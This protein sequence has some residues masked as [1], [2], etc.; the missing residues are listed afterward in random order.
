METRAHHILIGLFTALA[1]AGL[2]LFVMWKSQSVADSEMKHYDILFREAVSGLSVGS[3][4]QYSGIRVGDVERLTLD[5]QD[6][7][8]VW[9]RVRVAGDTPV[10]VDTSARLALLNIT[11]AS[12]IELSQGTPQ[13][14]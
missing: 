2:M 4:V 3:L 1:G 12:G 6:P 13:S 11:G 5:P 10:K 14:P 8:L 9:A 7:R